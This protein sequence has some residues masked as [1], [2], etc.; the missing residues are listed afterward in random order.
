MEEGHSIACRTGQVAQH[1]AMVRAISA[2]CHQMWRV[3][4]WLVGSRG[5]KSSTSTEST[6]LF[7]IGLWI[8]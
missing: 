7:L 1:L 6:V 2:V 5:K 8:V 3:L 4:F